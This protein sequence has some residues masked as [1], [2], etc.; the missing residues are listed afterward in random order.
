MNGMQCETCGWIGTNPDLRRELDTIDRGRAS[1]VVVEGCPECGVEGEIVPCSL[2]VN[3]LENGVD[4]RASYDDYCTECAAEAFDPPDLD[5]FRRDQET[6][7][8][9]LVKA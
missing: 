5:L 9:P 2:C 7:I 8:K 6:E 3:C 4:V 1:Y